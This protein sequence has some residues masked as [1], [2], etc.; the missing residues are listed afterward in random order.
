[1]SDVKEHGE[2]FT[3]EEFA[4]WLLA[5]PD[6]VKRKKIWFIDVNQPYKGK[7]LWVDNSFSEK[8]ISVEDAHDDGTPENEG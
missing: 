1:M 8:F 2:H 7:G 3:V 6:D 5:L 4:N